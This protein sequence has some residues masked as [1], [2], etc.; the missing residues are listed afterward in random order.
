MIESMPSFTLTT[1]ANRQLS[2]A[3]TTAAAT[4]KTGA[5]ASDCVEGCAAAAE[6][7]KAEVICSS[8]EAGGA[9]AEAKSVCIR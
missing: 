5:T 3:V 8:C 7:D 4:A 2:A 6:G 1:N 9:P